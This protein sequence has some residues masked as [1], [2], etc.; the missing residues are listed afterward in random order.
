MLDGSSESLTGDGW[1]PAEQPPSSS[2]RTSA[3]DAVQMELRIKVPPNVLALQQTLSAL[4]RVYLTA[5]CWK[6]LLAGSSATASTGE[7]AAQ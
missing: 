6:R 7:H 2:A 4:G 3:T 5:F 1:S